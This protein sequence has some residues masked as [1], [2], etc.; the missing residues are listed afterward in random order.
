MALAGQETLGLVLHPSCPFHIKP[1]PGDCVPGKKVWPTKGNSSAAPDNEVMLTILVAEAL[2]QDQTGFVFTPQSP[3]L[4]D[5]QLAGRNN[6]YFAFDSSGKLLTVLGGSIVGVALPN[7]QSFVA[8]ASWIAST[9]A[10]ETTGMTDVAAVPNDQNGGPMVVAHLPGTILGTWPIF[11]DGDYVYATTLDTT[12]GPFQVWRWNPKSG[13]G[14]EFL[15]NVSGDAACLFSP[16]G[17][18][19]E[20]EVQGT[21]LGL[22]IPTSPTGGYP[23]VFNMSVPNSAKFMFKNGDPETSKFQMDGSTGNVVYQN[24]NGIFFVTYGNTPVFRNLQYEIKFAT[25]YELYSGSTAH[26]PTGGSYFW[27][28][29]WIVYQ[30]NGGFWAY[31]FNQPNQQPPLAVLPVV[32]DYTVPDYSACGENPSSYGQMFT[33]RDVFVAQNGTMFF[34]AL[35]SVDGAVG[36]TGPLF[37]V[38]SPIFV[39]TSQCDPSCVDQGL[40]GHG[41]CAAGRCICNIGCSGQGCSK[42]QGQQ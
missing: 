25:T 12:K 27:K 21:L 1:L 3:D 40:G 5:F 26:Y 42:C 38:Q 15:A 11:A 23:C 6:Q 35:S 13:K 22:L 37:A 41:T 36:A 2:L 14:F 19:W 31:H 30:G 24:D 20:I 39:K 16:T 8:S 7:P 10:N 4:V 28:D 29:E 32:L 17:D 18:S 9:W 34:R 33:W